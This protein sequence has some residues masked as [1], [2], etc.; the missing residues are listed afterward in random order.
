MNIMT[1][2]K[3]K[4]YLKTLT[5]MAQAARSVEEGAQFVY[6]KLPDDLIEIMALDNWFEL[7]SGV[8]G[9]V[10]PHET[11]FKAVRDKAMTMFD[12]EMPEN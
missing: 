12:A 5:D 9:E 6:D 11:W 1:M 10:K 7:L 4:G 3:L 2:I 8:A